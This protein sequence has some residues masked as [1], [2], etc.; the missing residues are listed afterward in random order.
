MHFVQGNAKQ[1]S[2]RLLTVIIAVAAVAAFYAMNVCVPF[3][4]DDLL[5]NLYHGRPISSASEL[6]A[7]L[8][9]DY[10]FINGRIIAVLFSKLSVTLGDTFFNVANTMVYLLALALLYRCA[11]VKTSWQG[12][13]TMVLIVIG[14]TALSTGVDNL[15]YWASGATNYLWALVPTLLFILLID[16]CEKGRPASPLL[17]LAAGLLLAPYNEMYAFPICATCILYYLFRG[18]RINR[19]VFFLLTGYVV[20]SLAMALAPGNMGRQAFY[21]MGLGAVSRVVKMAYSLRITYV[22][23]LLLPVLWWKNK[24]QFSAFL[25]QNVCWFMLFAFSFVIPFLAATASRAMYAAEIFALV[26]GLR[27]INMLVNRQKTAISSAILLFLLYGIFQ[28]WA[29]R[30]SRIKWDIYRRAV[31]QY[32][33]QAGPTVM[34]DHYESASPLV[35]RYTVDLNNIATPIDKA[36]GLALFKNIRRGCGYDE[37]DSIDYIKLLPRDVYQAAILQ[38]DSF[39][40]PQNR[41]AG[42]GFY[43]RHD[44]T[45]Y[46]MPYDARVMSA[47]NEGRFYALYTVPL[48]HRRLKVNY[49]SWDVGFERAAQEFSTPHG[50]FILL[51]SKYKHYPLLQ[52]LRLDINPAQPPQKIEVLSD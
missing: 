52:L 3:F 31:H 13:L 12:P 27:A 4:S 37:P 9:D 33:A 28:C 21:T 8:Q 2:G 46:V 32:N 5:C 14:L 43:G 20:A 1:S 17:L 50:R 40:T 22:T 34:I 10:R 11:A 36:R 47:I 38:K 44:L 49:L 19:Y 41:I 24:R 48:I 30:D 51:N 15:H 25:R 26:I 18:R 7:S 29:V 23:A 16:R 6:W 39:F 45:Y 35:A 42:C